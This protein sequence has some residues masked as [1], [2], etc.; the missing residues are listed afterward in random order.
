M[1]E[2]IQGLEQEK[3]Y[4]VLKKKMMIGEN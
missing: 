3:T 1:E 2:H 4:S